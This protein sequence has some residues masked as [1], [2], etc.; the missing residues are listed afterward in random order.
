MASSRSRLRTSMRMLGVF[1]GCRLVVAGENDLWRENGPGHGHLALGIPVE[2]GHGVV[3]IAVDDIAAVRSNRQKGEHM[4]G[5]QCRQQQLLG[6]RVHVIAAVGQ[7][8]RPLQ[9]LATGKMDQVARRVVATFE[10]TAVARPFKADTMLRHGLN[11]PDFDGAQP[12]RQRAPMNRKIIVSPPRRHRSPASAAGRVPRHGLARVLSKFGLCSRAQA[13]ALVRAGRV[14][15]NG[16]IVI[17]PE[18]STDAAQD[19][20][21]VDGAAVAAV[22]KVYLMLNKPRGYV[23]TASDEQ[24]RQ[25][26]YALLHEGNFPWLAPVGRLDKASEGLLLFSNDSEWSAHLTTPA[27]QLDKTYHVQIDVIPDADLLRRLCVGVVQEGEHLA[28]KD[29][30]ELR[31]GE[32]NAWLEVVLDEG[33]NRQIRRLLTAFDIQVLRLIRVAIGPLV[34]GGLPRGKWR[35]LAPAEVAGLRQDAGAARKPGERDRAE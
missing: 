15:V 22:E 30:R 33:R 32:K 18:S 9:G 21:T 19:R 29:V 7:G 27:S 35:V 13:Q 1:V 17:D 14:Q 10:W 25:T 12:M 20:I 8:R 24:G 28:V 2:H 3:A 5:R 11:P 4:A 26:V 31:H 6:V 34:L 23:T 16:R